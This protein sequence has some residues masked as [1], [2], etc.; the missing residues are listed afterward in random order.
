VKLKTNRLPLGDQGSNDVSGGIGMRSGFVNHS[1]GDR[2]NC[3]E[4]TTGINRSARVE[5]Y[6]R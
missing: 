3:C 5:I 6:I 2:I 1:A 4:K